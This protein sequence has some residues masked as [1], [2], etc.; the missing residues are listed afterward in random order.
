MSHPKSD[1]YNYMLTDFGLHEA[2]GD[3]QIR[4]EPGSASGGMQLLLNCPNSCPSV[5]PHELVPIS[6]LKSI[7]EREEHR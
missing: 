1:L 4:V 2:D 7:L 3:T 5:L 6:L